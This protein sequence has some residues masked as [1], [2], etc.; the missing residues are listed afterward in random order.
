[1]TSIDPARSPRRSLSE[2]IRSRADGILLFGITPPKVGATPERM[3]EIAEVTLRRLAPL[4]LDGLIL[5][6]IDDESER[7][8]EDR[9]FPYLPTVDPARFATGYLA[10]WLRPLI[11]YR[12]V[13]K[14]TEVELA[15]WLASASPSDLLTVFVGASS[16]SQPVRTDLSSAQALRRSVRPEILLGAVTI[17]ERHTTR[18]DEHLRMIAKQASGCAFFV[19]QVV[20]DVDATRTLLSDYAGSCADRGIAPLPVIFTLSI[21]GSLKTLEFLEWLGVVVPRSLEHDLRCAT[22]PL[23]V[24]LDQCRR[25]ADDLLR[26]GRRLG[27]PVGFNVES[28]SI[29]KVEIEAAVTLAGQLRTLLDDGAVADSG[30]GSRA[31]SATRSSAWSADRE[32]R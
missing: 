18:G 23:S 22:D 28:V 13:G 25:A 26:F 30:P 21:C 10:G 14:Y 5:Y 8:D 27:V 2:L 29:R 7:V 32:S 6:D 12:C 11:V 24:S 9:P 4:D 31:S 19:S 20:Y 1:M 17:T 16:S 3:A 15:H